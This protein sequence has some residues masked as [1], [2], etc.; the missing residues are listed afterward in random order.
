MTI[1]DDVSQKLDALVKVVA[2]LSRWVRSTEEHQR[3][4]EASLTICIAVLPPLLISR[5]RDRHQ[6]LRD[7]DHDP[8]VADEVHRHVVKRMMQVTAYTGATNDGDSMYDEEEQLAPRQR[9]LLKSGLHWTGVTT[10]LNK[11]TWLHE[12]V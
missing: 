9:R 5:W 2:D 4:G 7:M 10:V 6:A 12:V 11:V 3:K 8:D 1:Q